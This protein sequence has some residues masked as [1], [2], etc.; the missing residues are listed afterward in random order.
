VADNKASQAP[1]DWVGLGD[2]L[3]TF[4]V[5]EE[6]SQS[7]RHIRELHWYVASRLVIEG[8]FRPD[9]IRPQP[10]FR[11]KTKGVGASREEILEYDPALGTG[12][13]AT[14]LGGLRTKNVDVVV[15]KEGI[16]PCIAVS[17]RGTQ[18]AFRNLTNRM[19]EAIGDC[20]NLHIAYPTLVYALLH[21]IRANREGSAHGA[22]GFLKPDADGNV[23]AQDVAIRKDGTP[24]E[25][26]VRFHHVLSRLTGRKDIRNEVSKYEAVA[27]AMVGID[28]KN[29]GYLLDTYPAT[30]SE[31]HFS[32]FFARIYD[33]YDQRFVYSAPSLSH[34]TR[35]KEWGQESPIVSDTRIS[36]YYPRTQGAK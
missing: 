11:V 20:T 2:A 7:S 31:L 30:E 32:R 13:E 14:V 9:E 33:Q 35:R 15:F 24:S 17:I 29:R 3:S 34:V 5:A 22:P 19:E 8:G 21:V 28:A 26:I 10:P 23:R 18:N 36:G 4:A 16:G 25:S 6:A 12:T 1:C 27:L